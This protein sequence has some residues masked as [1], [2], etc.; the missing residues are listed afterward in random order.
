MR[1]SFAPYR[2]APRPPQR[3]RPLRNR[4]EEARSKYAKLQFNLI[5]IYEADAADAA[6]NQARGPGVG[7]AVS[8]AFTNAADGGSLD[9]G[10]VAAR[11]CGA[12]L[13]SHPREREGRTALA[14]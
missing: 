12:R 2:R 8:V 1:T 6:S 14:F 4:A 13:R 11:F 7:H 5:R 9:L 10:H 3:R